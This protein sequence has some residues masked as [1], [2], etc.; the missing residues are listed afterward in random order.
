MSFAQLLGKKTPEQ[1]DREITLMKK[2]IEYYKML[3]QRNE[4]KKE[5]KIE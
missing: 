4:A 1:L 5:S 2:E 3:K